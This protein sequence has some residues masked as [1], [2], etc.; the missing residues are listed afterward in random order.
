MSDRLTREE[1]YRLRTD[2]LKLRSALVIGIRVSPPTWPISQSCACCSVGSFIGILVAGV[3][4]W[5]GSGDLRMADVDDMRVGSPRRS[6]RCAVMSCRP[7]PFSPWTVWQ[8]AVRALSPSRSCGRDHVPFARGAGAT[9]RWP[10]ARNAATT[11]SA[12]WLA[13]RASSRTRCSMI[14]HRLE[15]L[16]HRAVEEAGEPC[17]DAGPPATPA[18]GR[19]AADTVEGASRSATSR[20]MRSRQ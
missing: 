13:P 14:H 9:R 16:G 6:R 18:G 17:R 2:F 7:R 3:G 11:A 19:A 8:G 20:F 15:R 1:F 10:P 5:P 4:G 12:L